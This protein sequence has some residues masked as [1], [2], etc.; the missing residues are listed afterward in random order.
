M[1]TTEIMKRALL[2]LLAAALSGGAAAADVLYGLDGPHGDGPVLFSI[3]TTTAAKTT[4]ASL[5]IERPH[6]MG[7][8]D[9]YGY[10]IIADTNENVYYVD[11]TDGSID[12]SFTA[13]VDDEIMGLA[14]NG[15]VLYLLDRGDEL[16]T[17]DLFGDSAAQLVDSSADGPLDFDA[18]DTLYATARSGASVYTMDTT[19][20]VSTFAFTITGM[21]YSVIRG[22]AFLGGTDMY[23]TSYS[24]CCSFNAQLYSVDTGTGAATS[25]G[26]L[27]TGEHLI[28]AG[29]DAGPVDADSDGM[30]E[31]FE[32]AYGVSD[33]GA[34]PDGDG[35]TNVQEHDAGT[36]PKKAD[37]DGDGLNDAEEVELGTNPLLADTDYDGMS[38]SLE[39]AAGLDPTTSNNGHF[40]LTSTGSNTQHPQLKVDSSGNT[41]IVWAANDADGDRVIWY[42]MIDAAG[43]L[44][45]D[46]SQIG[47]D[48]DLSGG[49]RNV[50]Q[51]YLD[52]QERAWIVYHDN[53]GSDA[54]LVIIDPAAD[55]QAGDA[56]DAAA[57]VLAETNLDLFATGDE[58]SHP[59]L[60]FDADDVAHI[61][62][63]SGGSSMLHYV[64][65]DDAGATD[66]AGHVYVST[67]EG[68]HTYPGIAVDADG[69]VHVVFGSYNSS[70]VLNY[71]MLDGSS[72]SG[73]TLIDTTPLYANSSGYVK[74]PRIVAGDD[75]LMHI[76]FGRKIVDDEIGGILTYLA[77]DPSQAA[78]DGSASSA[79]DLVA[80]APS[81]LNEAIPMGASWYPE[82]SVLN[83][84]LFL[85]WFGTG[86]GGADI[87]WSYAGLIDPV[88]GSASSRLYTK[89]ATEQPSSNM[90]SVAHGG[91]RVAWV[92]GSTIHSIQPFPVESARF[93]GG[94]AATAKALSGSFYSMQEMVA[95]DLTAD[96]QAALSEDYTFDGPFYSFVIGGIP[97]GGSSSVVFTFAEDVPADAEM[98]KWIG[99]EWVSIPY[100]LGENANEV[101]V[102]Y[103]DGGSRDLDG[104]ANGFIVDPIGMGV[105]VPVEE[106]APTPAPTPINVSGGGGGGCVIG[107]GERPFDPLFPALLALAAAYVI[108]RRVTN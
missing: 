103:I 12:F 88:T 22:M 60:A 1:K 85:S 96:Q 8:S 82:L 28:A 63:E 39:V 41:H 4:I 31:L 53:S 79:E 76:V 40:A 26:S 94:A 92:E 56:L 95:A 73:A 49:D 23:V 106:P 44:L 105:P 54:Y 11:P 18:T 20:G 10:L 33:A 108:R 24:G 43:E 64:R 68:F 93:V 87:G 36:H 50:P 91:D 72:T 3:N 107:D 97:S 21:T 30:S 98:F 35:L 104:T 34:D 16:W 6:A 13:A 62:L 101:V 55:D 27:E 14:T 70:D 84:K 42:A 78:Q 19:T 2:P 37:T 15:A 90:W 52:S 7:Y 102:T 81:D 77:I 32:A 74:F 65:V 47:E 38:D 29:S 58:Y 61:V 17:S 66:L 45:V 69:N 67:V 86:G 80:R 48:S 57:V 5:D 75:G 89:S 46:Y 99:T 83:D 51:I 59:R 71:K 100:A 25:V 9:E